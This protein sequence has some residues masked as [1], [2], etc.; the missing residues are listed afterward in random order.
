MTFLPIVERELR[1]AARKRA[2]HWFRFFAA[3]GAMA[4]MLLVLFGN[5]ASTPQQS[6]GK[7]VFHTISAMA[8]AFCLLAGVFLT[9]DCLCSEKREGTLGLLLLTDL[10]GYDIVLG[11]LVATSIVSAC[12]LLAVIPMMGLP[13]VM[14]GVTFGEFVRKSLALLATLFLSLG[15][16]MVVSAICRETRA[17]MLGSFGVM[18]VL[19]GGVLGLSFMVYTLLDWKPA[20]Y[21]T[22]ISPFG[23]FMLSHD[24]Q[25]GVNWYAT[26]YWVSLG[27]AFALGLAQ[28][29]AASVL[30][31]R[32]WQS[33]GIEAESSNTPER[34]RRAIGNG[35]P[36]QW[37]LEREAFPGRLAK[38]IVGMILLTWTGFLA[39]TFF[40]GPSDQDETMLASFAAATT[41]HLL[42]KGLLA[43]QATR[44]LSEDRHSGALELLLTTPLD[45][46]AMLGAQWTVLQRQFRW[47][48]TTLLAVNLG[49]I[50]A[51]VFVM[52]RR[53]NDL[54]PVVI[55]S[56]FCAGGMILWMVDAYA[57]AWVGMWAALRGQRHLRATFHTLSCLLAPPWVGF[58]LFMFF[59]SG[60]SN[61][62]NILGGWF[63]WFAFSVLLS[64]LAAK[65][66]KAELLENF[67]G[68]AAGEPSRKNP[69][70]PQPWS[71][72]WETP[73]A[74][75][76][77][78]A[79]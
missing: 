78:P 24:L 26:G 34:F 71:P 44:R 56:I 46:R 37:L 50:L 74:T 27:L 66:R 23:A 55:F 10:K 19:N 47:F 72:E 45:T 17:A 42:A 65:K 33:S 12:A 69:A 20:E 4:A 61:L 13:L 67:R 70:P 31:P 38:I 54:E 22:I 15:V 77:P 48:Q 21:F 73:A 64:L 75:T 25:Y 51:L 60:S 57:L 40:A 36:F 28:L 58:L 1:V 43:L 59:T 53:W 11:K 63:L 76:N 9:S 14:G 52:G 30:L 2:T 79:A 6:L 68:M 16:G 41:L 35:N 32:S 62:A 29:I 18:V 8:F 39:G 49:L 5:P 7:W 3:L